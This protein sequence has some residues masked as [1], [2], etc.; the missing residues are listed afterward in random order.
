MRKWDTLHFGLR[1]G[2][3]E[4]FLSFGNNYADNRIIKTQLFDSLHATL[5]DFE[6]VTCRLPADDLAGSNILEQNGFEY[7]SGMLTLFHRC[8]RVSLRKESSMDI[9]PFSLDE[10]PKLARIARRVFGQDRFHQEYQLSKLKCDDLHS[11]WITNCCIKGLA[12]T[13]LVSH[14][15]KEPSGFIACRIDAPSSPLPYGTI[16]LVGVAPKFQGK[17]IGRALVNQALKWFEARVDFALVRTESAN[18]ASIK[19]YLNEGFSVVESSNYFR[20]WAK[21]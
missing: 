3:L 16:V 21:C 10:V 19:A 18:Y 9:V 6:Y 13:V 11:E 5:N 8:S 12:D 14:S 1:V 20:K 15:G 17:G 4:V 2:S 7:L